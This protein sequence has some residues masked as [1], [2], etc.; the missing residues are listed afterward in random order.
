MVASVL[1]FPERGSSMATLESHVEALIAELTRM[2]APGSA[3]I[4]DKE[5]FSFPGQI[6]V[7]D[8]RFIITTREMERLIELSSR[9]LKRRDPVLSSTHTEKKWNWM[10]RSA[11]A[12]R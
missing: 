10:V 2:Q 9:E 11:F 8:D 1:D 4:P 6:A 7:F 5:G 3:Q 12:Q